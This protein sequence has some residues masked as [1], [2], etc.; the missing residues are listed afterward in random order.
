VVVIVALAGGSAR[1]QSGRLLAA[2]IPFKFYLNDR[3]FPS[4]RYTVEPARAGGADALRIQS[5]DGHLAAIVAVR[6]GQSK[7][8]EVEPT[9]VFE[10]F[11][12]QYFLSQVTGLEEVATCAL[13]KPRLKEESATRGVAAGRQ[14]VSAISKKVR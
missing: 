6:F 4:G 2:N 8:N 13:P 5:A 1:A 14:A 12:D 7:T 3:A 10:R 11:G 9:L